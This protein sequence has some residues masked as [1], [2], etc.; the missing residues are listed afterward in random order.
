MKKEKVSVK[1]VPDIRRMKGEGRFPLKLRITF[2]GERKYYGTGYDASQEEWDK[3]NSA[4]AKGDLRKSKVEIASI[5]K[6]AQA[7]IE[8]ITPFSFKQFCKYP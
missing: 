8:G 4:E 1:V 5:E 7:C 6:R 2:K 3:I